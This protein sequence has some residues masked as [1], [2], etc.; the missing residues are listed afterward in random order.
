M[1]EP[2]PI[3]RRWFITGVSSGFGRE[4]AVAALAKGD[5]VIGTLRRPAQIAAFEALAPG[6]AHALMMDVSDPAQI[7]A[8]VAA[9]GDIAGG[10]DVLVNNAGYGFVGAAEEASLAEIRQQFETNFFG[11]VQLTQAVLPQMRARRTGRILN[12]SSG[13]GLM[14]SAGLG[15]YAAS[16]FA[17]EA[18]S[19]ALAAE[20]A[21][22]GIRVTLLEPGGF[23]TQFSGGS[24]AQAQ[25]RIGDYD[26]TAGRMRAGFEQFNGRQPGDPAKA[27]QVMLQLVEMPEPPLRL[28]LGRDML[29]RLRARYQ[30]ALLELDRWEALSSS[31]EFESAEVQA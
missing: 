25:Q 15:Y 30:N 29:P 21:A 1:S 23:R 11:L 8:A 31:T 22:L 2:Q 17:V 4:L 14:A 18:F 19:E 24:F 5:R 3:A 28:L 10:I 6:R 27:A 7:G 20:V 9:A 26:A 13:A 12:L 16:K